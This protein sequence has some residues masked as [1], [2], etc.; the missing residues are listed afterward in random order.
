MR[1]RRTHIIIETQ[2]VWLARLP[3]ATSR[4][5]CGKCGR[6]AGMVALPHAARLLGQEPE[7]LVKLGEDGFLHSGYG[8]N[9]ALYFCVAS[10]AGAESYE[11]NS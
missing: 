7:T 2:N 8:I 9:G 5:W 6:A 10:L 1:T 11:P 4:A 3:P